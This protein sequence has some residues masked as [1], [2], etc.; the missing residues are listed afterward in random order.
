MEVNIKKAAETFLSFYLA[1]LFWLIATCVWYLY[2]LWEIFY[3]LLHLAF[4]KFPHYVMIFIGCLFSCFRCKR[5]AKRKNQNSYSMPE[6]YRKQ[7]IPNYGSTCYLN[8]IIQILSS[9]NEFASS[10][11]NCFGLS[12]I[13]DDLRSPNHDF[14][15]KI[16]NFLLKLSKEHEMVILV[17]FSLGKQ[18]DCKELYNILIETLAKENS[19]AENFFKIVKYQ[20]I[21][22]SM[23]HNQEKPETSYFLLYPKSA[24]SSLGSYLK[25]LKDKADEFNENNPLFCEKCNCL[26]ATTIKIV[27]LELPQ[28]L[29]VYLPGKPF[30][31]IKSVESINFE[32]KY[33]ELYGV[34]CYFEHKYSSHYIACTL[35]E[36]GKWR[37]YN[38]AFATEKCPDMKNAYMLFYR[39]KSK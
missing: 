27:S 28:I 23:N 8:S 20:K 3:R 29:A 34:I 9:T 39:V 21:I 35:D 25:D 11:K 19:D 30:K 32:G 14:E 7:G 33:Y 18:N 31:S 16:Q 15:P 4:K 22:C 26:R 5:K 38:D 6:Q 17:Q 10:I 12:D 36:D 24:N 1:C 37:E 2:C 13:F